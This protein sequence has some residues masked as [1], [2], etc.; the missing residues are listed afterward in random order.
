MNRSFKIYL[1]EIIIKS[2]KSILIACFSATFH[3][4]I[5]SGPALFVYSPLLNILLTII[6]S[7]FY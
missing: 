1:R 5:L 7:T 4:N 3:F 6:L 2:K